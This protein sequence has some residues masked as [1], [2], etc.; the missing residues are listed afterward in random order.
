MGPQAIL[1]FDEFMLLVYFSI[2]LNNLVDGIVIPEVL[3][4]NVWNLKFK[5]VIPE[6]CFVFIVLNGNNVQIPT[7]AREKDYN[8]KNVTATND[9]FRHGIDLQGYL[10]SVVAIGIHNDFVTL[11]DKLLK[12]G[13]TNGDPVKA[14]VQTLLTQDTGI[15]LQTVFSMS[16]EMECQLRKAAMLV[17]MNHQ[18]DSSNNT[19]NEANN[20]S[21]G[22]IKTS[23]ELEEYGTVCWQKSFNMFI[24]QPPSRLTKEVVTRDATKRSR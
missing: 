10:N 7:I 3:Y 23:A 15:F 16:S 4:N 18:F 5:I 1:T 6:N 11:Y 19:I 21:G 14:E 12:S 13:I 2:S 9:D 24:A 20:I 8:Y 17:S 22:V